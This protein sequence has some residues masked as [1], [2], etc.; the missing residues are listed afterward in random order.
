MKGQRKEY[1]TQQ[2][3]KKSGTKKYQTNKE[4]KINKINNIRKTKN[5]LI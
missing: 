1:K 2:V 3:I 4:N 5:R